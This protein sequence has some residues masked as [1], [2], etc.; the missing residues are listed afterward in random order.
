MLGDLRDYIKVIEDLIRDEELS[1]DN[2]RVAVVSDHV[3]AAKDVVA[4]CTNDRVIAKWFLTLRTDYDKLC[5]LVANNLR[6]Q[7]QKQAASVRRQ[8]SA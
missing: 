1:T 7:Q 3:K 8:P 5:H 6:R 2:K 4:V